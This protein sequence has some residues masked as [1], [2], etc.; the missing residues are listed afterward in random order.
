MRKNSGN[1]VK[2]EQN[3]EKSKTTIIGYVVL[4][5][6]MLILPM[7]MI[8]CQNI[9][10]ETETLQPP[11]IS[12]GESDGRYTVTPARGQTVTITDPNGG[13]A[14]YYT[15]DGSTPTDVASAS[16]YLYSGPIT[17][18]GTQDTTIVNAR[19]FKENLR[20][21]P[22]ATKSFRLAWKQMSATM[23][24]AR[25]EHGVVE[26]DGKIYIIGGFTGQYTNTTN[27]CEVYN[28]ATGEISDLGYPLNSA[29]A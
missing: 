13:A 16:N 5:L 10:V 20:D 25:M 4:V 12:N 23:A 3:C 6:F 2:T 28:V 27:T 26:V 1:F 7:V 18:T 11:V 24:T 19:A 9:N 22:V 14:I 21:S 29:R 17:L 15:L 8:S